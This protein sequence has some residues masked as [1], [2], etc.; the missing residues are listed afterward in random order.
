MP[1]RRAAASLLF[2]WCSAVAAE[3]VAIPGEL[4]VGPATAAGIL[5]WE[6]KSF[7]GETSYLIDSN[8]DRNA[9]R[10]DSQ[11]SAS[12]LLHEVAIDLTATPLLHWSWK[13]G[14]LLHGIDETT[15]AG[16]DYPAR[17]YVLFRGSRWDPRPLSLSYVWS[18]TQPRGSAWAN[19][20]TDRVIMVAVR[21]AHDPVGAWVEE[22]HNV[23]EDIR[24]YFGRE[25]NTVEAVAIMTDTDDSGQQA[26][27]WYGDI[28]FA[29]E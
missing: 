15:R 20:Y 14:N 13:V 22:E 17:V 8:E 25:V 9:V 16:D 5:A 6:S 3:V 4:R 29:A 1:H 28:S 18:S 26:T 27:A 21:D 12:A 2:L 10:A 23:R 24:R 11:A 7:V 19:A